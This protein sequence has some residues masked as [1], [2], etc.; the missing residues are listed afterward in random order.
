MKFISKQY[1]KL[2]L[3]SERNGIK[4]LKA[5]LATSVSLFC[6]NNLSYYENVNE[7]N[8]QELSTNDEMSCYNV[9]EGME[10]TDFL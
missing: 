5:A 7:E 8:F 3:C 9:S 2:R 6:S 4:M 1:C 10:L